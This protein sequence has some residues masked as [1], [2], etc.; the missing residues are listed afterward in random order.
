MVENLDVQEIRPNT[1][2]C[3][4]VFKN[5]C[6]ASNVTIYGAR[7]CIKSVRYVRPLQEALLFCQNTHQHYTHQHYTHQH[8]THQHYTQQRLHSLYR[9]RSDTP[10]HLLLNSV[11]QQLYQQSLHEIKFSSPQS[12][13]K[14]K[15]PK[16]TSCFS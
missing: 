4:H 14:K 1:R 7:T 12:F 11:A 16:M 9:K 10:S 13:R 3:R 5:V 2:T 6:K 15:S 8:Y